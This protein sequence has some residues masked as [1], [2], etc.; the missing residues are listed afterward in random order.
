MTILNA[1]KFFSPR[2]WSVGWSFFRLK[3][4]REVLDKAS[5]SVLTP[6]ATILFPYPPL[7][8]ALFTHCNLL[9]TTLEQKLIFDPA[10]ASYSVDKVPPG[11]W[12]LAC[13]WMFPTNS[14]K[15]PMKPGTLPVPSTPRSSPLQSGALLSSHMWF[16]FRAS[17]AIL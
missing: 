5:A 15:C 11:A 1:S 13:L 6:W 4:W 7:M 12:V 9:Q 3:F 10:C 2:C 17:C 14:E 8:F 16:W